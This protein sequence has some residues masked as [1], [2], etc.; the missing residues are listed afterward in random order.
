MVLALLTQPLCAQ[1]ADRVHQ[2][3]ANEAQTM[4][5]MQAQDRIY[6]SSLMT[7]QERNEYQNQMRQLKTE[8]ER[9]DFQAQY[10]GQIKQR[11]E[12]EGKTLPDNLPAIREG[13]SRGAGK[14][15][16]HSQGMGMDMG[17]AGQSMGAGKGSGGGNKDK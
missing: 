3:T 6:G 10:H 8:Q 13:Q 5:Q 12:A 11:A 4:G 1:E 2:E 16:G 7:Q 15:M 17:Q 9:A 14:G